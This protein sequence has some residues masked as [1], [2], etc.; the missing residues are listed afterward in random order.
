M[1]EVGRR[2]G[3][4]AEPLHEGPVDGE[5]G[6]QDLEGDRPVELAVH[7]PVDLRHAAAGDQVGQLVAPRVDAGRPVAWRRAY[8]ATARGLEVPSLRSG[9][10][11]R[12][13]D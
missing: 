2:L 11:R 13:G 5:L 10:S 6:E 9:A 4:P 8:A 12:T 3:L 1:G 7:G